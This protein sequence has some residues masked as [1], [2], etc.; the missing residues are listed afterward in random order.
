MLNQTKDHYNDTANEF[1]AGQYNLSQTI[2]KSY[3]R[4][5]KKSCVKQLGDSGF[6]RGSHEILLL[7]ATFVAKRMSSHTHSIFYPK[8]I[9]MQF[10]KIGQKIGII[11]NSFTC[12]PKMSFLIK[13]I[14]LAYVITSR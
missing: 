13:K 5:T 11:N 9:C 1:V 14:E 4:K 7:S 12:H 8:N 10:H 6:N 2:L 3:A